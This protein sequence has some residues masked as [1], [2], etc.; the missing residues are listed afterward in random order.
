MR[1]TWARFG[2]VAAAVAI[3]SS[4][5]GQSSLKAFEVASVRVL[6][7]PVLP[8]RVVAES[9]V[10]LLGFPM[11]ELIAMAYEIELYRLI[12]PS[13]VT[14]A[15]RVEIRAKMPSGSTPNDLPEMLRTLLAERFGMAAHF[16]P[17]PV[18]VYEL[19]VGPQGVKMLQV[20]AVDDR[21][22]PF[23][24]GPGGSDVMAGS[25]G[26]T[27]MLMSPDG[28]VRLITEDTNIERASTTN[29]VVYDATRARLPQLVDMVSSSLGM[30]VLDK[31]GLTGLYRFRIELPK[32]GAI[33]SAALQ[34]FNGQSNTAPMTN[35]SSQDVA[36]SQSVAALGLRLERRR[37]PVNVLVVDKLLRSP[38]PN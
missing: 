33:A 10:E 20:A 34:T 29:T 36:A 22:T 3:T 14:G 6:T 4:A 15:P 37:I 7:A 8:K 2:L 35:L 11:R 28:V 5:A 26:R 38:T 19:R 12:V 27:R 18:D 31:T 23:S 32:N 16:E 24:L 13:W 21:T 9:R 30:P 17:R 25:E 1:I